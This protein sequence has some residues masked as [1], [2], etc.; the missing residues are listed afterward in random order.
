MRTRIFLFVFGLS[1][2]GLTSCRTPP[3]S[4]SLPTRAIN[5]TTEAVS[6]N[7]ATVYPAAMN[8]LT[9]VMDSP[10]SCLD[11]LAPTLGVAF[12]VVACVVRTT[13]TEAA[14]QEGK[15]PND[16]VTIRKAERAKAWID[17]RNLVFE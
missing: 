6:R 12:E 2:G 9:A 8:C 13:G 4:P 11:S 16:A 7:W 14:M 1:I 10:M 17:A 3:G 15:N 5:C